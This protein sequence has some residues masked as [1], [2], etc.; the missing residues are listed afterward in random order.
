[1][2]RKTI[3]FVVAILLFASCGSDDGE[4][5]TDFKQEMRDF[6]EELSE[7][8]KAQ[9][10]GFYIIPQNG[11]EIVTL[12]GDEDAGADNDYL[13]AIDGHGQE[14]LFFGYHQ[15]DELTPEQETNY[16]TAFLNKSKDNGNV[17]LVTDYC[18]TPSKMEQSY[19]KG[20]N[21]GYVSFAAS[22]RELDIIPAFPKP[23]HNENNEII[24]ELASVKNFLYLINPEK[25]ATKQ[26]FIDAV[27]ATNYDLVI[28]DLFFHDD[29]PFSAS[30]VDE[31]RK[32]ANGGTR[33][34]IGY[35]SIGEAE[36]Y[37]YYWRADWDSHP[38]EWIEAENPDWEGNYKVN[39]WNEDWKAIIFGK[40]ESYLKKIID[41]GFDGAYLDIIDAF[42]YFE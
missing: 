38:P 30:E 29:V 31:L 11:V 26:A 23:I 34:V 2:I 36:D 17:V 16:L 40:E 5:G 18:S 28:M 24:N 37:R 12:T 41:A 25:F 20:D 35:L 4:N 9:K 27:T 1:M 19:Q 21:H 13:E 14:D 39:Y 33:L 22:S 8:A 15:D 42:E 10:A 3:F 6:V 32:K 7:Y